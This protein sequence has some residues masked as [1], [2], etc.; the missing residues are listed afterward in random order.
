M[1]LVSLI[2]HGNRIGQ[3]IGESISHEIMEIPFSN[4]SGQK[5]I[6]TLMRNAD[7]AIL[8][9]LEFH[10]T[11]DMSIDEFKSLMTDGYIELSAGGYKLIKYNFGLCMEL[12]NVRKINNAFIIRIPFEYTIGRL[13]MICIQ[14]SSITI[15]I[16]V[17]NHDQIQNVKLFCD[18]V[19]LDSEPR[20]HLA[21]NYQSTYMQNFDV[22]GKCSTEN[23]NN[24][25]ATI[26]L[27]QHILIKGYF[28]EGDM[29]KIKKIIWKNDNDQII[30]TYDKNSNDQQNNQI[31]F[32]QISPK[33]HF[34][35]QPNVDYKSMAQ[36]ENIENLNMYNGS[37]VIEFNNIDDIHNQPINHIKFH[38]ISQ[39]TLQ[40][41]DGVVNLRYTFD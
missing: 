39:N 2:A 10:P 29:S 26:N 13:H 31:S 16:D 4:H 8:R 40:Y 19:Y 14:Y 38:S 7:N 28:I 6:A 27:S 11:H 15:T 9:H 33:L 3:Y 32:K 23:I 1:A 24:N 17:P 34:I 41:G 30:L 22:I 5:R 18:Y 25:V 21:S 12:E 35:S 37:A 20:R 36:S